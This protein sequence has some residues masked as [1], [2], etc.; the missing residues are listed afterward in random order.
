MSLHGPFRLLV[1]LE[2]RR[3]SAQCQAQKVLSHRYSSDIGFG[4]YALFDGGYLF[5]RVLYFH[6]RMGFRRR[7]LDPGIRRTGPLTGQNLETPSFLCR[8]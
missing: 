3:Q 6:R 1:F 8:G 2:M 4:V 5:A 7:M